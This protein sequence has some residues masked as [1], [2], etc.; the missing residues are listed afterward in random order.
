MYK[1]I[2]NPKS[3]IRLFIL[4]SIATMLAEIQGETNKQKDV[5][6]KVDK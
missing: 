3:K 1:N 4:S 2:Y 6:P 5:K